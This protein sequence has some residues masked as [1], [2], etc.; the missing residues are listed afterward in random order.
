MERKK[1]SNK[2]QCIHLRRGKDRIILEE[3]KAGS[4]IVE[5]Y[6]VERGTCEFWSGGVKVNFSIREKGRDKT[7]WRQKVSR[8]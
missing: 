7:T 5:E 1:S 6:R 8:E 3:G 4:G 2:Q